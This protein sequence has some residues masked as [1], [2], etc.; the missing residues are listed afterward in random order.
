MKAE[1]KIHEQ[2]FW[3]N[4]VQSIPNWDR[5]SLEKFMR[6]RDNLLHEKYGAYI[7]QGWPYNSLV[8][9]SQEELTWFLLK[10]S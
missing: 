1:I 2:S 4:F 6:E 3:A 9:P 7:K 8:F 10:W 5:I